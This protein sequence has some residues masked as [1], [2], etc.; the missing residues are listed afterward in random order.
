MSEQKTFS[1][2]QSE[3]LIALL[4]TETSSEFEQL[5]SALKVLA[6][7]PELTPSAVPPALPSTVHQTIVRLPLKSSKSHRTIITSLIAAGILASASLA[8]AA[9]TGKG[10]GPIVAIANTTVKFMKEMVGAVTSV[11]TGN[12]SS[13]P[14]D[15][16]NGTE[17]PEVQPVAPTPADEDGV[18]NNN[19][20]DTTEGPTISEPHN[21]KKENEKS[22]QEN[23]KAEKT[24]EAPSI[25]SDDESSKDGPVI[26][27]STPVGENGNEKAAENSTENKV[28][29]TPA[30]ETTPGA[31]NES[32]ASEEPS[33]VIDAE[34]ISKTD[35][36]DPAVKK[37][38]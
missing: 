8:A 21:P 23:S 29:E 33:K 12:N 38:D 13:V 4:K 34:L 14:Q 5:R 9:V 36:E 22:Q 32:P 3:E 25:P 27:Q 2:A 31:N 37:R 20:L 7:V 17:Q 35:S 15:Q 18:E 24:P 19:D 16:T 26:S 28:S 11:V 1:V 10:P 30:P 6:H